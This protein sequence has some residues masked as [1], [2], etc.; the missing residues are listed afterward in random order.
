MNRLNVVG[1]VNIFPE[2]RVLPVVPLGLD[3]VLPN[4]K[5]KTET[6][7]FRPGNFVT[8]NIGSPVVMAEM[9]EFLDN[10]KFL[11][12]IIFCLKTHYLYTAE[13]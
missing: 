8:V 5:K 11:L 12:Q 4:P 10:F 7:I 3:R 1:W 13:M 6:A 9:V 2:G